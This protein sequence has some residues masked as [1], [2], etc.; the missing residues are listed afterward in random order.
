MLHLGAY[1]TLNRAKSGEMLTTLKALCSTL[2]ISADA[3]LFGEAADTLMTD[4]EKILGRIARN[5][6]GC[7]FKCHNL[8]D[9][10]VLPARNRRYA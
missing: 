8:S 2:E 1:K 5:K 10:K 4:S 3:L 6:M 7:N 9:L